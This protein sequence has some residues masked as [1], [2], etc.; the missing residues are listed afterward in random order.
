MSWSEAGMSHRGKN[1]EASQMLGH[2]IRHF[3]L[4]MCCVLMG[5]LRALESIVGI[6]P[7]FGG[8]AQVMLVA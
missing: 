3:V 1:S 4:A 2:G 8:A 7:Y 5:L 6:L